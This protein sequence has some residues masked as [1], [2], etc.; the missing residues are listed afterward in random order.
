M[1]TGE[2]VTTTTE[3]TDAADAAATEP[4]SAPVPAGSDLWL[5]ET[6]AETELT[7]TV[8]VPDDISILLATDGTAPAPTDLTISWPITNSTPFAGP[9]ILGG[10][11]FFVLGLGLLIW[12]FVHMRR[13]RGP[14]RKSSPKP[15]KL[16]R[17]PRVKVPR[18]KALEPET[19]AK[20][21]R[22]VRG[23]RTLAVLG[24]SAIVLTGCSN[25][26]VSEYFG[27]APTPTPS[28]SAS[29][30]AEAEITPVAVTPSQVER[31]L[32]E[33]SAV[34]TQA[35]T[36]RNADLLS[37]RFTG[38]ALQ[39]RQANYTARGADGAIPAPEAIPA[40]PIR[41]D[42]P[43][44]TSS[45][46]RRVLAV[47]GDNSGDVAPTALVLIQET[48]RSQY[49]V[50][51]AMR[52]QADTEFPAVAPPTVGAPVLAP[53]NRLLSVEPD[54]LGAAYADV[55][56]LGDQSASFG[57]FAAEP[58][59][60]RTQVGVDYKNTKRANFPATASIEFSNAV[61]T[62][63][64]IAF[65]SNESGAIVAL[66]IVER[67]TIRPTEEGATVNFTGGVK[68]LSGKESSATGVESTYGYQ[69]LF[70][71]PPST[72]DQGQVVL[73]GYAQNL[74]SARE[75]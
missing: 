15:P 2:P 30:E 6:S 58:D 8:N 14:R 21:R 52:L 51:Y 41:L 49:L 16:P 32:T 20:G 48:P 11:A 47:V 43:E 28:A 56:A 19:T 70:Y 37:T 42:L 64:V 75:L 55:L 23:F 59:G 72:D 24:A 63:P 25:V 3:A 34:A 9:L 44:A 33:V 27:D 62:G 13:T 60:L 4:A 66:D 54:L 35:D 74:I 65:A 69:L 1:V 45:W 38:P 39:E 50:N 18:A 17:A 40:G 53:D 26:D 71:V 67:E 7:W 57:I 22:A 10:G 46:P 73:L 29:A 61:G 31:I 36:D 68:A 5:E 12:G